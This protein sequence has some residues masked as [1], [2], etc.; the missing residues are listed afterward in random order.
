M[1]AVHDPQTG[2]A[3]GATGCAFAGSCKLPTNKTK[4]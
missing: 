4:G 3:I 2:Q 1:I